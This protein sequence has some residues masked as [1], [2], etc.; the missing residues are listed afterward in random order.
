MDQ[1]EK[2]RDMAATT[3]EIDASRPLMPSDT[4][5]SAIEGGNHAQ[6]GWNGPQS[7]DTEPTIGREERQAQIVLSTLRLL[8]QLIE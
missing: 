1:E 5:W 6:T 2:G 4:L 8:A 3:T 7:G